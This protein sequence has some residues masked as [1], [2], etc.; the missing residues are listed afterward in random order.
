MTLIVFWLYVIIYYGY[1]PALCS[2]IDLLVLSGRTEYPVPSHDEK[3]R[4]KS[5]FWPPQGNS[6]TLNSVM[7]NNP[8]GYDY[9]V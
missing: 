8:N 7:G 1:I 3:S 5:W 4:G 2:R 6:D 9:R